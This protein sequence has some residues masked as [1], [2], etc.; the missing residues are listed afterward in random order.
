MVENRIVDKKDVLERIDELLK[1]KLDEEKREQ[2]RN[3]KRRSNWFTW[4]SLLKQANWIMWKDI[5]E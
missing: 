4:L 3:L 5:L 2:L 1:W